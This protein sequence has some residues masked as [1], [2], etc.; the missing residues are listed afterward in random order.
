MFCKLDTLL[1]SFAPQT[2]ILRLSG[3]HEDYSPE[4]AVAES[5]ATV[6][7]EHMHFFQTVTSGFGQVV[8]DM[9][10]QTTS[11]TVRE[12]LDTPLP[13]GTTTRRRLPLAHIAQWSPEHL[14]KAL[15]D[16]GTAQEVNTIAKARFW[17]SDSRPLTLSDLGL[18]ILNQPWEANPRIK[19]NEHEH[20]L[21]GKEILEG[22]AFFVERT[23]LSHRLGIADEL[24]WSREGVPRVYLVALDWFL[25]TCG[26]HRRS[27]FPVICDLALQTTHEP[28]LPA[29]EADWRA[30]SPSWR[31]RLLSEALAAAPSLSFDDAH[32]DRDYRGFADALLTAVGFKP[33]TQ[34][35]EERWANLHKRLP[36]LGLE[37]LIARAIEM[38]RARPWLGANPIRDDALWTEMTTQLPAPAVEIK[39]GLG[40][41][42]PPQAVSSEFFFELQYQALALQVLGVP[43]RSADPPDTIQCGFALFD[44]PQACDYQRSHYCSG[45]YR[46]S[47]GPPFPVTILEDAT[48]VG[49]PFE[50]LLITMGLT[51]TDLD[52]DNSAQLPNTTLHDQEH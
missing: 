2:L 36:L 12:W 24:A 29:T 6:V 35:L 11:Y 13:S 9:H 4:G 17:L 37:K 41:F 34:V 51:S 31:F 52:I 1:G 22:H 38:R 32:V 8:W 25:Q 14:R 21:Q 46:P 27:S 7:H 30:T 26:T 43:W 47:D 28:V 23:M 20:V 39:G 44:L 49:C 10:R 5:L 15:I 3:R 19:L 18:R 42:G 33:L 40:H 48:M 45:R 16:W 50:A